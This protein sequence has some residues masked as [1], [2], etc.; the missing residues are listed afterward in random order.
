MGSESRPRPD[1]ATGEGSS[2]RSFGVLLFTSR[3]AAV[4]STLPLGKTWTR[5]TSIQ[6]TTLSQ[7]LTQRV[8]LLR[9]VAR[10]VLEGSVIVGENN[11][12]EATGPLEM[13]VR[14]QDGALCL[15]LRSP[16]TCKAIE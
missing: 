4:E 12:D 9:W 6:K 13:M 2:Q 8:G 7:T 15:H 10:R 5:T 14:T 1:V 11:L 3:I 16:Y